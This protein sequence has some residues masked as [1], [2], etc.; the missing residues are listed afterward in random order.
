[1][2][3]LR[4][5]IISRI[6]GF[7]ETV[8]K[9]FAK[10]TVQLI[11]YICWLLDKTFLPISLPRRNR[12]RQMRAVR[13]LCRRLS[14]I[15][16]KFDLEVQQKN[17]IYNWLFL[18]RTET[19]M[20]PKRKQKKSGTCRGSRYFNGAGKLWPYQWDS[21]RRSQSCCWRRPWIGDY[22][23]VSKRLRAPFGTKWPCSLPWPST[24]TPSLSEC[25]Y[26]RPESGIGRTA[27]LLAPLSPSSHPLAQYC[28]E[29][30]P[31][32]LHWSFKKSTLTRGHMLTSKFQLWRKFYSNLH[33]KSTLDSL[34]N[35]SQEMS[36]L[37]IQRH[38]TNTQKVNIQPVIKAKLTT[39][40]ATSR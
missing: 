37:H 1:M 14:R 18:I 28:S 34:P 26:S 25:T 10:N 4:N 5:I 13:P 9:M 11:Y 39:N 31:F 36:L 8:Q 6:H 27:L 7:C 21:Y 17:P 2:L 38:F 35:C 33:V 23:A 3:G 15:D 40:W 22:E 30:T 12:R 32:P 16:S 29:S 19:C 20:C 24:R